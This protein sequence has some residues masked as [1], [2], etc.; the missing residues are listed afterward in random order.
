MDDSEKAALVDLILEKV[1]QSMPKMMALHMQQEALLKE[2]ADGL[3]KERPDLKER[4]LEVAIL[5]NNLAGENPH[6][7]L[8]EL[9]NSAKEA[10]VWKI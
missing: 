9:I 10:P 8:E 3:F 6:W 7:P 5:I 2:A 1:F 4:S